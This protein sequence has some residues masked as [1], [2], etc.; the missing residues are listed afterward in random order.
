[1]K[2]ICAFLKNLTFSLHEPLTKRKH[3]FPETAEVSLYQSTIVVAKCHTLPKPSCRRN[4]KI[5]R[6]ISNQQPLQGRTHSSTVYTLQS[7]H[8]HFIKPPSPLFQPFWK[9][10]RVLHAI[11]RM[12]SE[13][14]GEEVR[15]MS[16]KRH[17]RNQW[18]QDIRDDAFH[19]A[20]IELIK[21]RK[22]SMQPAHPPYR[23]FPTLR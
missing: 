21:T 12:V 23:I 11:Q 3:I 8:L 22:P 20:P 9:Q 18:T 13:A 10:K 1:M 19:I 7:V 2:V 14:V 17:C 4:T 15:S 6:L 5:R 16:R